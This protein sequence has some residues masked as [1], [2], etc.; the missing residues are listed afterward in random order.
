MTK[1]VEIGEKGVKKLVVGETIEI[2]KESF[3]RVIK[4]SGDL[5]V[6]VEEFSSIDEAK[7]KK[8]K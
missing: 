6:E 5:I 3:H 7:K 1:D 8:T 4:G 2:P